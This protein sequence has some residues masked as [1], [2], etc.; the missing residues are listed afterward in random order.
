LLNT[1]QNVTDIA[2]FDRD[3]SL[4]LQTGYFVVNS[5]KVKAVFA[6]QNITMLHLSSYE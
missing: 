1:D 3:L 6:T 4:A 5:G 2:S